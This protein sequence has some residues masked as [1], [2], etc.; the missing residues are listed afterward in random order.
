VAEASAPSL[1][2]RV[3]YQWKPC[4]SAPDRLVVPKRVTAGTL[5]LR[6]AGGSRRVRVSLVPGGIVPARVSLPGTGRVRATLELVT[7][8]VKVTNA[9]GRAVRRISLRGGVV[10]NGR[11]T[12]SVPPDAEHGHFNTLL[13]LQ[14]AARVAAVTAPRQVALVTARVYDGSV[15][16]RPEVHFDDPATIRVGQADGRADAEWEPASL[17]HE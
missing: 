16:S 13:V 2:A 7:P 15:A 12:L 5:V 17:A 9:T 1:S 14:R 6:R 3:T 4:S 11:V 8:R 10:K